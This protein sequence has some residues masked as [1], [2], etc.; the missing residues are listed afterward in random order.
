MNPGADGLPAGLA[1]A[2]FQ[3][4]C[5][6]HASLLSA[7]PCRARPRVRPREWK[8]PRLSSRH[9]LRTGRTRAS[10]TP[11]ARCAA[12]TGLMF[13]ALKYGDAE[14]ALP[15]EISAEVGGCA[16]VLFSGLVQGMMG[17]KTNWARV[18]CE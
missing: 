16:L 6:L 5:E 2:G 15:F 11:P 12:D 1:V 8:S 17:S 10:L 3:A 9:A 14:N 18:E 4:V 7:L 13:A